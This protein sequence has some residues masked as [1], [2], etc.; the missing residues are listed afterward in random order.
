MKKV[1]NEFVVFREKKDYRWKTVWTDTKYNANVYGTKLVN[2]IIDTA[3]PFPK[4]LYAVMD[5]IRAIIHNKHNAVILDFFAGSGTTGHAVME[6]NKQDGGNRKFIL[7]TNNEDNNGDGTK[8]ATDILYPRIRNVIRGYTGIRDKKDYKGLGGNLKYYK[9]GF[10]DAE[11]T[12]KNKR[13]LV[14]K[15]TEMLCLREDCFDEVKKGKEFRIFKDSKD[16][17][18]GI[19]Y[20]DE[21]IE[22]FKSE[23]KKT[24]KKFVVYVFSLDDST[25]EEEFKDV[26]KLVELKPI[27][28]VILNVYKRI[29][30]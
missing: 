22:A 19:I 21:G 10:V 27:P 3:F 26:R 13:D 18:L 25:R 8:I 9:T 20:D 16:K 11:P 30:K 7:C 12:D 2:N 5:S 15:S 4:S 23:A 14:D 6:L 17:H 1:K 29:F 28:A 24:K